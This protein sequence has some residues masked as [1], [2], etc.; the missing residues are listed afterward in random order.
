MKG[1]AIPD[2]DHVAR[3]CRP[4]TIDEGEIQATAFMLRE[5]E[6]YLSVNWLEELNC[7]DRRSE[8][9]ALQDLYSRTL[10]VRTT[11]RIAILSVGASRTKV[12]QE[13]PDMR[14]LRVLHK[15]IIPEDPSH[16]GIYDISPD[17]EIIAELI[18]QSVL[19]KHPA[20]V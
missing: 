2:S 20:R 1:Q 11:A 3:Y 6:E 19:E 4:T 12:A 5:G 9:R 7:S 10:S 8:I 14:L 13:S 18:A 15:P 17:D 16:A